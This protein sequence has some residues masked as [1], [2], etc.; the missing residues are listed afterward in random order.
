[1][2]I[3]PLCVGIDV[4]KHHLDLFD[5]EAGSRRIANAPEPLRLLAESL[6]GRA[7]LAVFEATGH[8]DTALR[9]SLDEAGVAYARVNPQQ[10]R[11]FARAIGQ[12]AKTDPLDARMLAAL[13]QRLRPQ[14]TSA[15]DPRRAEIAL[16]HKRRDQL[17]AMRQQERTRLADCSDK[18]LATL[19]A[20][21]VAILG[22]QIRAVEDKL[23]GL[24][25]ADAELRTTERRLRS[26]PGIGPVTAVTLLALMPELGQ[27][28]PKALAAL[29]GLAPFNRDSGQWR[30]QRHVRGGRKRVR[31]ALYMAAVTAA[32]SAT[33]LG[34]FCQAL[35]QN[36]KPAK[37]ALIA[38]ARKLL[39]ILNAIVRDKTLF[40]QA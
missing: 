40:T 11:D 7:C 21:H 23:H 38:L 32:R 19:I 24:I 33:C 36:G 29:A 3:S 31:D 8:Y 39:V 20:E 9:R 17:V 1:M 37:L 16:W 5:P 2:S 34:T 22:Q 18:A 25:G 12:R 6:R 35:R 30:G 26:V 10:A 15:G 4:S 14:P 27:R 28:S 13:G